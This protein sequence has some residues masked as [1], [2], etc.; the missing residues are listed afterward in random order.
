MKSRW[1]HSMGKKGASLWCLVV[2][3]LAASTVFLARSSEAAFV[4]ERRCRKAVVVV[5]GRSSPGSSASSVVVTV[6]LARRHYGHCSHLPSPTSRLHQS[7][8]LAAALPSFK[9]PS[10]SDVQAV[11]SAAIF[12]ALDIAFRRLFRAWSIAFPSSLGACTVLFVTLLS[13]PRDAAQRVFGALAPGAALLAKWLPVFFVPSLIALPLAD[14]VGSALEMGKIALVIVAGFFVTLLTTAFSVTAV[15]RLK[16]H[17]SNDS[18]SIA[19]TTNV[20]DIGSPPPPPAAAAKPPFTD[21][22]FHFLCAST[23]ISAARTIFIATTQ[24][25][26][27]SI[28]HSPWLV[29]FLLSTTLNSFVFGARLPTKFKKL[30]HPLV[31]CTALTWSAM[32]ALGVA[33]RTSFYTL[34]HHYTMRATTAARGVMGAGNVLLFLL[35][36]AVVSLAVSMYERRRLMRENLAE[37]GTAISVSTAGGLVGTALAVRWLNLASP[38]L[39][40]SLLSRNITSPL[41]MAIAKILGADVSLAVSMVV[42]TGLIGANFG[43]SILDVVRVT[44]PV[45]RGLGIGAAAHGLGTAAFANEKDAFP[46]AAIAMALTATAATVAV[47]IPLLRNCLIRLALGV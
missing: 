32:A 42:V 39:R 1:P 46:F 9:G 36:P 8:L 45:A 47:S 17:P 44:D 31:T 27:S 11:T 41:A 7:S 10:K 25:G 3:V 37:V 38:Y 35:G 5:V 6:P 34:L 30:V 24:P 28:V 43:A 21:E 23:A 2:V 12:V 33:A 20:V 19:T 40:L 29:A 4:S 26:L 15:R 22:L 16:S 18:P 13:L 14:S